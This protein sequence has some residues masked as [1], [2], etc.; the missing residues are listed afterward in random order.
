MSKVYGASSLDFPK[1]RNAQDVK[2]A[3][4]KSAYLEGQDSWSWKDSNSSRR[5]IEFVE[6][7]Q[8]P[9]RQEDETKSIS[10]RWSN[11]RSRWTFGKE[12]E[13]EIES[14]SNTSEKLKNYSLYQATS[15]LF[16]RSHSNQDTGEAAQEENSASG[17]QVGRQDTTSEHTIAS[18]PSTT[19]SAPSRTHYITPTSDRRPLS[20]ERYSTSRV[21]VKTSEKTIPSLK[22]ATRA[23]ALRTPLTTRST[24]FSSS[25]SHR[26]MSNAPAPFQPQRSGHPEVENTS[27]ADEDQV[28]TSRDDPT[29]SSSKQVDEPPNIEKLRGRVAKLFDDESD[30]GRNYSSLRRSRSIRKGGLFDD[31][32]D[33]AI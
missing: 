9:E 16:P 15:R 26:S 29:E 12:K 5:A 22:T 4:N 1:M 10:S 19:I 24:D 28:P 8:F 25:T 7:F 3:V 33:D 30:S 20:R 17:E 31:D 27:F 14:D 2:N 6:K 18:S 21:Q 11:Y 32:E 13:D 23:S